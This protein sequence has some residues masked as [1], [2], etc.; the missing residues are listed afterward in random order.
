MKVI[1][2]YIYVYICIYIYVCVCV[3]IYIHIYNL[4]ITYNL[5]IMKKIL[6]IFISRFLHSISVLNSYY[7][8]AHQCS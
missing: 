6:Y 1:H 7:A 4:N 2:I 3:Y 5:K 8:L